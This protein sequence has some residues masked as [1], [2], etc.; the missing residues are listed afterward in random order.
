MCCLVYWTHSSDLTFTRH[1]LCTTLYNTNSVLYFCTIQKNSM[2]FVQSHNLMDTV[3]DFQEASCHLCGL[4]SLLSQHPWGS[5]PTCI[6]WG[7]LFGIGRICMCAG[8]KEKLFFPVVCNPLISVICFALVHMP[9]HTP[10]RSCQCT[11]TFDLSSS[12]L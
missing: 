5:G 6:S 7:A 12:L 4:V 2:F 1:L 11:C 8:Y 3:S 10:L 9:L